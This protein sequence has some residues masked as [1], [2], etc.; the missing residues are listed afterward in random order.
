MNGHR[1]RCRIVFGARNAAD[2]STACNGTGL[3]GGRENGSIRVFSGTN[4]SE[5]DQLDGHPNLVSSIAVASD[6]SRLVSVSCDATM[7][8]WQRTDSDG[9]QQ[10]MY[11]CAY[12]RKHI[13]AVQL[14]A[15]SHSDDKHSSNDGSR[16]HWRK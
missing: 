7:R 11:K 15:L 3:F 12:V 2:T 14:V 16:C 1:T 8:V 6:A 4:G 10:H 13:S 5:L 9:P